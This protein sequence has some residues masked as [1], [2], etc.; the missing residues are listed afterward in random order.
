MK[1]KWRNR[2]RTMITTFSTSA[3]VA[4]LTVLFPQSALATN[5]FVEQINRQLASAAVLLYGNDYRV[6][7]EPTISTL[8]DRGKLLISVNLRSGVEYGLVGVCDSDC[9]DVD[10]KLYDENYNLVDADT[11]SDDMPVVTVSPRWSGQYYIEVD[12][13]TCRTDYCYYGVGVF[14]RR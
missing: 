2:A 3:F 8:R 4:G 5:R 7:H 10:L 9:A 11:R 6:T 13:E 12:M 14:G 1:L